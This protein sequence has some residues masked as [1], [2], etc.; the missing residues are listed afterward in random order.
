[1]SIDTPSSPVTQALQDN[2]ARLIN[3]RTGGFFGREWVFDA[4][5][6]WTGAGL[7]CFLLGGRPGTGK[8]AIASRLVQMHSGE[9]P[10]PATSNQL[11]P[12][13]LAYHHFCQAGSESTLSPQDFVQALAESLAARYPDFRKS[14]EAKT[15]QQFNVTVNAGNVSGG[16]SVTGVR[17]N[18]TISGG[19]ARGLFDELVRRPLRDLAAAQPAERIIILVDSLDEA[20][21]FHPTNNIARLVASAKDLPSSIG[22]F[23]TS[24]TGIDAITRLVGDPTLDLIADAPPGSDEV[25]SY[26]STRLKAQLAEPAL[27]QVSQR[28]ADQS[29][30]NF[31]YAYHVLN[32]LERTPLTTAQL[33]TFPF[34][35]EL[36]DLYEQM[37][38]RQ[39]ATDAKDWST[40]FRPL[41]GAIAVA[42]GDGLTREQLLGITGFAEDVADDALKAA[43]EYLAGGGSDSYRVYHHSFREFLL[44]DQDFGVYPAERHAATARWFESQYGAK[45]ESCRDEYALRYTARHWSEAAEA[46]SSANSRAA[47]TRSAVSLAL[48][49]RYRRGFERRVG[50]LVELRDTVLHAMRVAALNETDDMLPW[51]LRAALAYPQ[52]GRDYLQSEAVVALAESGELDEALSRLRMFSEISEN[53]QHVARQIL[54]WL[55]IG[56]ASGAAEAELTKLA[57][58]AAEEPVLAR[59]LERAQA[60]L[61]NEAIVACTPP[62]PNTYIEVGRELV[63]RIGGNSYDQEMLQSAINPSVMVVPKVSMG[64]TAPGS[65]QYAAELDGPVLVS[66]ALVTGSSSPEGTS[67]VDEY[68]K[69]HAGYNYVVYRNES[70]W[71]LLHAVLHYMP[72]QAWVRERLKRMLIAALTGGAIEFLESLPMTAK[73]LSARQQ[74]DKGK[75]VMQEMVMLAGNTAAQLLN[76]RGSNDVWGEHKRRLTTLMELASRVGDEPALAQQILQRIPSLPDGFAGFQAP[77]W[78]RYVDGLV[79]CGDASK[80]DYALTQASV[81]AQHIQ[82]YHFCAR[83]NARVNALVRWHRSP[84]AT[85]ELK[86]SIDRLVRTPLDDDFASDH[87]VREPFPHRA[88]KEWQ[89]RPIE[90][91]RSADTLEELAE[92]FQR[93]V[94]EFLPLNPGLGARTPIAAG[95]LVRVPDPGLAP[96]LAVH[97]AARV[98]SD[99]ALEGERAGLIRSLIPT[100]AVNSTALDSL[101]SY[102]LIAANVEDAQLLEQIVVEAGPVNFANQPVPFGQIGP[103]SVLPA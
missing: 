103:D 64:L 85:A 97:L 48:N 31:L 51:V 92:V 95:T 93:R 23:L 100:A 27:S 101:L 72:D 96:L 2:F 21:T 78:L 38:S 18:I 62:L 84:L 15:S 35:N 57:A 68:I 76:T 37:M 83:V 75:P 6:Q 39:L 80:R 70:L 13:F 32:M 91:A 86:A 3:A 61:R 44:R 34:P 63:K 12:G 66:I 45:W 9:V 58:T 89:L 50:N 29:R 46:A 73:L 82:D 26:A 87:R 56:Q 60:A 53:W 90:P 19:D 7:G 10:A 88:A 99:P 36:E 16:G 8:T 55:A 17:V 79:V 49:P 42:H 52:F 65:N 40:R 71:F 98:L 22:F 47:N 67:L 43:A 11:R 77:A 54:C 24:R 25:R 94:G 59:L 69:A 33:E 102:L 14:L 20:L 28:L 5:D 74:P 81:S 30:G 4:V 41:L 1:M